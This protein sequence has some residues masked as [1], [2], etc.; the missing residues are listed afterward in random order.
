MVNKNEKMNCAM[1]ILN[2]NDSHRAW[3]LAQK[4]KTFKNI[5]KIIIVDNKSTDD[6]IEYFSKKS[7]DNKI[8]IVISKENNGFASGNNI[9]ARYILKKYSPTFLFFANTD[10]IFQEADLDACF[11][12][13]KE[14]EKLALVSMRMLDV[15][16]NEEKSSWKFIPFY[17]W[18][19]LNFW[20]YRK[21][22]FNKLIYQK[23]DTDFQ[24]V[25]VVRGSFM[26]F[27]TELF[28]KCGLFD[29]NTFLYFEEDIISYKLKEINYNVGLL[30]NHFYIHNH[31]YS[32]NKNKTY[33]E[34][35]MDQSLKYFLTNYYEIGI[36]K[37]TLL[38]LCIFLGKIESFFFN[39]LK[40]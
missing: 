28:F 1:V 33:N 2:Y 23:F 20:I 27:K 34:Y 30:T 31:I 36:L 17:K 26:V 8:E 11:E 18:I 3:K 16:G 32:K 39:K 4:C 22:N 19:L 13:L 5:D 12:K 14:D 15:K 24:Y 25:D 9:G 6:S 7:K 21:F 38:E 29:E 40:Q 35:Y 10:T 37:T